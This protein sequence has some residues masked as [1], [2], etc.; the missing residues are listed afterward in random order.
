MCAGV[1]KKTV[2]E[3]AGLGE[4]GTGEGGREGIDSMCDR[5]DDAI[6]T[7]ALQAPEVGQCP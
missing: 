4:E 3:Y 2:N 5:L 7:A 1:I 6:N